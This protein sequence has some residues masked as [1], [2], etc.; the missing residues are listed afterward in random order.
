[1]LCTAVYTVQMVDKDR[2]IKLLGAGLGP[3]DVAKAI[4]CDPSL[5]SQ[6]LAEDTVRAQ[7]LA[8][9]MESLQLQT[10]RDKAIDSIEDTLIE[11]LKESVSFLVK[12]REIL[13]AFA[14]LNNAKRR[15]A[16][17]AGDINLTQNI[18]SITL[19]PV[20]R[21]VYLPK[22]NSQG[23]VVQV[24]EEITTTMPLQQLLASRVKKNL[25]EAIEVKVTQETGD[26]NGASEKA[27]G[28]SSSQGES[29]QTTAA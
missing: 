29:R 8:L 13:Q 20:A 28:G 11:K 18:V 17:T 22:T 21:Q 26:A 9:R 23:E 4:G 19:P 14:V 1:M 16:S 25:A 12:P 6:W 15:G 2:G 27:A 10:Q 7:V 24:G 3:V 5:V